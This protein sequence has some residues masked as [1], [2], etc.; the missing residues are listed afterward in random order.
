MSLLAMTDA[1]SNLDMEEE[2][3]TILCSVI[4]FLM[5]ISFRSFKG[6]KKP[7]SGKL[8]KHIELNVH[9]GHATHSDAGANDDKDYVNIDKALQTAFENEDYWQVLKCWKQ[10]KSFKQSAIH[11]PM[12]I[13]AMRFC[14]KGGY[15]IATELKD[16]FKAHPEECSIGFI[17]DLL[18]PLA[19]RSDDAQLVEMLV[20]AICGMRITMDSRTYEIML[21]MH[22]ASGNLAKTQEVVAEM[23]TKEVVFTPRATVAVLTMGLQTSNV[24]VVLKAFVKLKPWWD[25][26]DTWPVSM[27]ALDR[28]KTNVLMQV[29]TL[30]CQKLKVCELS[31]ALDGMTLPEEVLNALLSQISLLSDDELALSIQ[32]LEKGGKSFE[33]DPIYKTLMDCSSSRSRMK[34]E[35][36]DRLLQLDRLLELSSPSPPWKSKKPEVAVTKPLPPWRLK[37]IVRADSD[38]STSEGSKSDSEEESHFGPCARPPPGLAAAVF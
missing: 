27:F 7:T 13:R 6:K 9:D 25:E 23:N 4:A 37:K 31:S 8:F 32:V 38:A 28:H 21:T 15:F 3:V 10:L 35:E 22:S 11:L 19:R 1:L 26:R 14:N 12:I 17:N 18:E 36:L 5:L 24:D 16:F 34:S 33:A 20:R 2:L 30:A 29:V